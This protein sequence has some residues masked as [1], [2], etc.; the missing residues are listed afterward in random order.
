MYYDF[1]WLV[2]MA[3]KKKKKD[4]QDSLELSRD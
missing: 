3:P 1:R 2:L 4:L